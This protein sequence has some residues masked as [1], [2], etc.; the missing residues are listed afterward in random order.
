MWASLIPC[1]HKATGNGRG[2]HIT[3]PANRPLAPRQEKESLSPDQDSRVHRRPRHF[4]LSDCPSLPPD[5]N[6]PPPNPNLPSSFP[7]LPASPPPGDRG[8]TNCADSIKGRISEICTHTSE[9]HEHRP[10]PLRY[11]LGQTIAYTFTPLSGP[12]ES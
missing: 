5:L 4:V 3:R 6:S 10:S 9:E 1:G 8:E 12:R 11:K 7:P 2:R